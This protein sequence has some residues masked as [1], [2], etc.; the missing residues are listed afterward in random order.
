MNTNDPKWRSPLTHSTLAIIM[1]RRKAHRLLCV[2]V[3]AALKV[4]YAER[5]A[6]LDAANEEE[7][8]NA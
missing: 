8:R 7:E 6:V 5:Q 2:H 3:N 4:I 1:H